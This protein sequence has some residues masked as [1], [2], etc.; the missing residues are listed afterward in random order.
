M[1]R[2]LP[3][4][5]SRY[6]IPTL[7]PDVRY[8]HF[9]QVL[10]TIGS[11]AVPQGVAKTAAFSGPFQALVRRIMSAGNP[12]AEEGLALLAAMD[13]TLGR[14]ELPGERALS[15][16][17]TSVPHQDSTAVPPLP[18]RRVVLATH[19]E[20]PAVGPEAP[21]LAP[22]GPDGEDVPQLVPQ[23][24]DVAL[25]F[26]LLADIVACPHVPA[27]GTLHALQLLVRG[28]SL[29][30][31]GGRGHLADR[32]GKSCKLQQRRCLFDPAARN[33]SALRTLLALTSHRFPDLDTRTR[34]ATYLAVLQTVPPS[35]LPELVPRQDKSLA[36]PP[37]PNVVAQTGEPATGQTPKSLQGVDTKGFEGPATVGTEGHAA[38]GTDGVTPP[39][40]P[41]PQEGERAR[42]GTWGPELA[43]GGTSAVHPDRT[44]VAAAVATQLRL[45]HWPVE[46]GRPKGDGRAHLNHGEGEPAQEHHSSIRSLDAE[47]ADGNQS[48]A[49]QRARGVQ[50]IPFGVPT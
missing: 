49:G 25:L 9:V 29:G 43:L 28:I 13:D 32:P 14:V 6:Q 34:A 24:A 22:E 20:A 19:H 27:R 8:P 18:Q 2:I 1:S 10:S 33:S 23:L 30:R 38:P 21:L 47:G 36:P 4:I 11:T 15:L 46:R 31:V 42:P 5:L 16:G 48:S 40:T 12:K 45:H 44:A 35:R 17:G 41:P 37:S 39:S 50:H 7:C 26:P 3:L